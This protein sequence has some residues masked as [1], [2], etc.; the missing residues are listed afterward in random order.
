MKKHLILSS[1]IASFSFI[2]HAYGQSKA[3]VKAILK[4][5]SPSAIKGNMTFLSDDMLEGRFP[6]TKGFALASKF[7]ES[8]FISLG[9]KPGVSDTSY[10]QRVSLRQ[11][12]PDAA[13]CTFTVVDKN[14]KEENLTYGKE[15]LFQ[16]YFTS[17]T[18]TV[19]AELVFV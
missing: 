15:F 7:M 12:W 11:G 13:E 4:N 9:L 3:E 14:G 1:L 2:I 17:A 18:S 16:P 10:T 6:G 19:S 5:V 8:Q